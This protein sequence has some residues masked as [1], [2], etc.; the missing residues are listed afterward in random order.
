VSERSKSKLELPNDRIRWKEN[1]KSCRIDEIRGTC[2]ARRIRSNSE[3]PLSA[4]TA[5][6]FPA[7]DIPEVLI[8]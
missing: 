8:K 2:K 4:T 6:H 7:F 5:V 1:E 3:E